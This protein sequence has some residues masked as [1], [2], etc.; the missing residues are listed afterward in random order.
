MLISYN[1]A[2]GK[3]CSTLENDLILCEK[4]GFD[5]IEIRL[6]MLKEYLNKRSFSDLR[7]FFNQ[8]HLKPHALNAVYIYSGFLDENDNSV[9]H[10]K[11]MEDFQFACKAGN[12]IGS[13]YIIVVPPLDPSGVFT[14]DLQESSKDCVRILK[15]LSELARPWKMNLCFELVGL[16]K[17]CVRSLSVVENIVSSVNEDNVGYVFD[18][19]NI[20]LNDHCNDCKW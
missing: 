11:L 3:G 8:N 17:S 4:V 6:D 13:H 10:K 9:R 15:Q 12:E 20:Y 19:Y 1:E 2:C 7:G 18:S 5:Y 16:K 14:G